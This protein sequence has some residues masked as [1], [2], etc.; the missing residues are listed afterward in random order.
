MRILC[1]FLVVGLAGVASGAVPTTVDKPVI[2]GK[3]VLLTDFGAVGDGKT[4]CTAAFAK[5]LEAISA[6]RGGVLE[7]PRGVFV[8][9]PITLRGNMALQL[10][11]G[12]VVRA[13]EDFS[14]FGLPSPLPATQEEA[15]KLK[16]TAGAFITVEHADNFEIRGSGTI[17]GSGE[18]WWHHVNK[19]TYYTAGA[20]LIPRPRLVAIEDGK[21]VWVHDVTLTDSPS[22]HLVPRRCTNVLIEH[23]TIKAPEKAPNT[24]AIDPSNCEGVIIRNCTLDVGDDDVAIK[25][26]GK[27]PACDDILVTD[28]TI[29]HG[30]GISIGSETTAGVHHMLVQH[31]TMDGTNPALRIKSARDR[32]GDVQDITYQDI[33]MKNIQSNAIEIN[34]YYE[35]KNAQRETK[36]LTATTPRISDVLF[37]NI[38]VESAKTAG[39]IIGLPEAPIMNVRLENVTIH[40]DTGMT[41]RDAQGIV[42][43]NTK[44][45]AKKGPPLTTSFA[46]VEQK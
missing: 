10:D 31:L 2:A 25:S 38:T 8:S 34:T 5:A 26:G 15:G 7:V 22:F 23:V 3:T 42:M 27:G 17:D 20:V 30:H 37:K 33:T 19:P 43:V 46:Q 18:A 39:V 40:A 28:C 36:P 12:A 32:G 24:D 41:V 13:T 6:A 29:R 16:L 35:D 44:I 14:A 4:L 1:A 11:E 21:D 9:G 45:D